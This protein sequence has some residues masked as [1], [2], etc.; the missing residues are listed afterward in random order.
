MP[1]TAT[2][3]R[4][5]DAAWAEATERGVDLLTLARVAARAG[6]SRQA[7]YLHFGNRS[8]LL[9]EMARRI[10]YSSGFRQRLRAARKHPPRTAF[11]RVLEEWYAY[12]PLI[13]P[14][15]RALEAA[16]LV[17]GEG[18]AAYADRMQ[19]WRDGLRISAAALAESGE[20]A[21]RWTVDAATDWVWAAVHPTTYHH[22]VNDCD[23]DSTEVAA[24]TIATLER[25]L[26]AA[27]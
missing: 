5:P 23:W 12:L 8:T 11:R 21:S 15:H 14:V 7:V 1:S 3:E 10:D 16:A 9:V 6:V 26:Y 18:A 19:D 2:R 20:L 27:P 25:E 4:L 17:G 13:L 22:L 24:T